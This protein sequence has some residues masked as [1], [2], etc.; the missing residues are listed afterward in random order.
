[1]ALPMS[2]RERS[3]FSCSDLHLRARDAGEERLDAARHEIDHRGAGALVWYVY[4]LGAGRHAGP[5]QAQMAY[6]PDTGRAEGDVTR[7]CLGKIDQLVDASCGHGRVH[8]Q[9]L[10]HVSR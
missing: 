7:L 3:D 4:E 8:D 10:W 9:W 6:R 2:G 1:Q 5:L